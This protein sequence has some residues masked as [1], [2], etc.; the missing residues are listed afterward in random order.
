M[1]FS[2]YITYLLY[3]NIPC[4][5]LGM[6]YTFHNLPGLRQLQFLLLSYT[7]CRIVVTDKKI[8]EVTLFSRFVKIFGIFIFLVVG[9]V[10]VHVIFFLPILLLFPV[11]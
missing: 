2:K 9:I 5:V 3:I 1:P 4:F 10:G 8:N 11:L 7:L 6:P